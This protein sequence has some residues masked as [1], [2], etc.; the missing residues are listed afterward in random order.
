VPLC[1]RWR[2]LRAHTQ[3]APAASPAP[4]TRAAT[5]TGSTRSRTDAHGSIV[6]TVTSSRSGRRF[7]LASTAQRM[8]RRSRGIRSATRPPSAG[9]APSSSPGRGSSSAHGEC[10]GA[11]AQPLARRCRQ[12]ARSDGRDGLSGGRGMGFGRPVGNPCFCA[13]RRH[14]GT[15]DDGL[16]VLRSDDRLRKHR[17]GGGGCGS[18]DHR[19]YAT[20]RNS[21][22]PAASHLAH[23]QTKASRF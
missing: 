9:S 12:T 21:P 16:R 11:T 22:P 23:I 15:T 13:R 17:A 19:L 4:R 10:S 2:R 1:S 8:E 5:R 14:S 20:P 3:P 6:R 18:P 7:T